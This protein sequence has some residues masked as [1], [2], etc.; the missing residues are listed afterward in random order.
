MTAKKTDNEKHGKK[1]RLQLRHQPDELTCGPS[2]VTM[3]AE[4]QGRAENTDIAALGRHMGTDSSTGT[5]PE[6]ISHGLDALGAEYEHIKSWNIED[7][8]EWLPQGWAILRTL[9]H[10]IPHWVVADQ[11]KG[12]TVNLLDPWLGEHWVD[13]NTLAER[14]GARQWE[15]FR[16]PKVSRW[17]SPVTVETRKHLVAPLAMADL[18]EAAGLAVTAFKHLM[19]EHEIWGYL[20][21]KMTTGMSAGLWEK[22]KN[23]GKGA[24]VG[25]YLLQRLDRSRGEGRELGLPGMEES[26]QKAI[27]AEGVALVIS[28]ESQGQGLSH[29]LRA[30]ATRTSGGFLVGQHLRDLNNMDHWLK[31][32]RVIAENPELFVT[33]EEQPFKERPVN[34]K[35][36]PF[37]ARI[38][39]ARTLKHGAP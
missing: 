30:Y 21:E 18:N 12:D 27:G 25:T 13:T 33:Y 20:A 39:T 37:H 17:P 24:M 31:R 35:I 38:K 16:I 8:K 4:A 1:G 5:T 14:W 11:V 6:R 22:D 7:L 2:C 34:A 32:R 3:V 10:N 19:A 29:M 23:G 15:G 36:S 9:T 26:D 28:P